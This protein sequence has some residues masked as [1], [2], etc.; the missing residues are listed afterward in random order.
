MTDIVRKRCGRLKRKKNDCP[1]CGSRNRDIYS[2]EWNDKGERV[3]TLQCKDCNTIFPAETCR[4][5]PVKG[6][7]ACRLCGGKSPAGADSPS[8]KHGLY[9]KY[10][11]ADLGEKFY[12]SVEDPF[13]FEYDQ[14]LALLRSLLF[15][16]L[17][18]RQKYYPSHYYWSLLSD[19]SDK[20][21]QAIEVENIEMIRDVSSQ[22]RNAIKSAG[23]RQK[24]DMEIQKLE[25][26]IADIK[27][28]H[29]KR[30]KQLQ[31]YIPVSEFKNIMAALVYLFFSHITDPYLKQKLY[32]ELKK[33]STQQRIP[34][35]DVS[36]V[37][38]ETD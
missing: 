20:L 9:S 1:E 38:Q 30:E 28:R 3:L 31:S 32:N 29:D 5:Y 23:D 12:A 17:E 6:R 7:T 25:A 34:M 24:C 36:V 22:M 16:R 21:N 15:E 11:P 14:D 13:L 4:N 19:L 10:L 2:D 8:Y 35:G 33:F 18:E 37:T 27:S 26:L